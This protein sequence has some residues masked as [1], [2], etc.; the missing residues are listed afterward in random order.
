[1][2]RPAARTLVP[3][4]ASLAPATAALTVAAK[5]AGLPTQKVPPRFGSFQTSKA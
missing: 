3:T 5:S 4:P 1:M 2:N